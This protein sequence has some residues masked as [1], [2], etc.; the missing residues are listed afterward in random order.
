MM[1]EDWDDK[2]EPRFSNSIF[3]TEV[4]PPPLTERDLDPLTEPAD[5][6][7]VLPDLPDIPND[8]SRSAWPWL[9]SD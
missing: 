9:Y 3:P 5:A 1:Y 7:D 6:P 2:T 4:P 8:K